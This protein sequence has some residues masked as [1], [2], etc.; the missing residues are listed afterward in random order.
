MKTN[1]E[2]EKEFASVIDQLGRAQDEIERNKAAAKV[3]REMLELYAT[4]N[5]VKSFK[6]ADYALRM[7]KDA[8]SLKRSVGVSEA[9]VVAL[10]RKDE[11]TRD[12]I[13]ES[14]NSTAL[15]NH[16]AALDNPD[17]KLASLGL[18]LT[19]T[20]PHAEIKALNH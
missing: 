17:E 19:H 9:N 5:K 3:L 8:P 15:K 6:T 7:V 11:T 20:V 14:Y 12:F 1:I 2:N 4:K 13:T 16:V 18:Y 10:L